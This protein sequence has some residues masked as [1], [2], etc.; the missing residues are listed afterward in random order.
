MTPRRFPS[1]W[2]IDESEVRFIVRDHDK[3][4]LA[5]VYYENESGRRSS[6]KLLTR[7][8]A[9]LIAVNIAKLPSVPRQIL[10][11]IPRP[12]NSASREGKSGSD[13]PCARAEVIRWSLGGI[14]GEFYGRK[15]DH[16]R[17][18]RLSEVWGAEHTGA[19]GL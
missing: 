2:S 19:C 11:D 5:Y 6:A 9:F 15:Y 14:S 17:H 1:P 3:Q 12:P 10:K 13:S 16:T 7:D 8:E 4:A 18:W